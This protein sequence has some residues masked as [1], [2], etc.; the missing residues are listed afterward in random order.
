MKHADR[1]VE[2]LLFLDGLPNLQD[3]GKL[4][5]GE[6]VEEILDCDLRQEQL[7]A[8][9]L[10]EAIA[11]CEQVRDYITRELLE[12]ILESEEEH[13]DWIEIQLGLIQKMGL[14]NYV[15]L[16]SEAAE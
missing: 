9:P 15:Q 16:Q 5:I 12:K 2:R 3:L 13:I 8:P 10:R 6:N 4:L 1:L 7:A 11:Y 14:Q